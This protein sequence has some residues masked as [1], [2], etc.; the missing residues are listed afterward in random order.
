M[1]RDMSFLVPRSILAGVLA[2]SLG[3]ASISTLIL[4]GCSST[5]TFILQSD[6]PQVPD[7]EQRLGIDVKRTLGEIS[8]G[9]FVFVGPLNDWEATMRT[10]IS[11]FRDAGWTLERST[12]GF[13][14]SAM[15]FTKDS[16]CDRRVEVVLDAD[17][18]EPA[19][20]RAQYVVT[21]LNPKDGDAVS[22]DTSDE[23]ASTT[24]SRA[25]GSD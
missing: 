1:L 21:P 13:P 12:P 24:A 17:Q 6:I 10:L 25:D 23:G 16:L 5:P 11:R 7:M 14:R 9:I 19:M 3:L 8:S 22:S 2:A 20:S 4:G 15:V 18:L